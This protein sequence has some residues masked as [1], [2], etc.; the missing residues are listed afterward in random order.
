VRERE[1]SYGVKM[2]CKQWWFYE[3]FNAEVMKQIRRRSVKE[4]NLS[5]V[6]FFNFG[7]H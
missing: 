6:E 2:V 7:I 3:Y 1:G 5:F 4:R